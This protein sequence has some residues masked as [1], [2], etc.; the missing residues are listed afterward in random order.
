MKEV[1]FRFNMYKLPL[2]TNINKGEALEQLSAKC[3][4]LL[5]RIF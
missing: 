5:E 1:P 2:A 4:V 3:I